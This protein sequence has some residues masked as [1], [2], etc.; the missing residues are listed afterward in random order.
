MEDRIIVGA[1]DVDPR[2]G[3]IPL[4]KVAVAATAKDLGVECDCQLS[5]SW[6]VYVP[7]SE[8]RAFIELTQEKLKEL[9]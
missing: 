8:R 4:I 1:T 7:K 3:N 9:S 6:M 2:S 5:M